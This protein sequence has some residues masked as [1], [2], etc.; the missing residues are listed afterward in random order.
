MDAKASLVAEESYSR[1]M[2]V[3]KLATQANIWC[4]KTCTQTPGCLYYNFKKQLSACHFADP[5]S[6]SKAEHLEN[7]AN[8]KIYKVEWW[9]GNRA[10][11]G[12]TY[13]CIQQ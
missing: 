11:L 8:W 2:N 5:L 4:R 13:L 3:T 7:L 10:G 6:G 12:L 1:V 9:L